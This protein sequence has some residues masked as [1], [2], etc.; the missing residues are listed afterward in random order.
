[1]DKFDV[2]IIGSAHIDILADYNRETKDDINKEGDIL[3]GVGGVAFNVAANLSYH[4]ITSRLYTII[5][6]N[7]YSGTL[8]KSSMVKRGMSTEFVFEMPAGE[9]E[10]GFVAHRLEGSLIAG[11]ASTLVDACTL[12]THSLENA[13]ERAAL[14]AVECN[15]STAQIKQIRTITAKYDKPLF[16]CSV[17]ENKVKRAI[18]QSEG[19]HYKMFCL[20]R[21]EAEKQSLGKVSIDAESKQDISQLCRLY[22]AENLIITKGKDGYTVYTLTGE[23]FDFPKPSAKVTS[24]LGA[25]DALFSA[26]LNSYLDNNGFDWLQCKNK[27]TRYVREALSSPR[28][29]PDALHEDHQDKHKKAIAII[30]PVEH[31]KTS[32][33]IAKAC[34][35]LDVKHKRADDVWLHNAFITDIEDMIRSADIIIA[36]L[37]GKNPA[38]FYEIGI[39]RE[40]GKTIIPVSQDSPDDLPEDIRLMKVLHFKAGEGSNAYDKLTAALQKRLEVLLS[41]LI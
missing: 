10:I 19:I 5:K 24:E 40:M 27:I 3:I 37:T 2:L 18:G 7:S 41:K 16:V 28:A 34:S 38:I 20:N 13:V 39:A 32:E 36:D 29:T 1:M 35:N 30:Y 17:A 11:V 22:H 31:K 9:S 6:A 8:I 14:V 21:K 4:G 23:K 33:A 26:T 12:K 15:L 25:G